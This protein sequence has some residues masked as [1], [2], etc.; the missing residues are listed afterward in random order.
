V[1]EPF[2]IPGVGHGCHIAGPTS[3]LIGL[4]AYDAAA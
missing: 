4:H 1:V 3:L 2:T